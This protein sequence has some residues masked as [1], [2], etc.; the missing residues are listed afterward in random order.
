MREETR[1][2]QF[3][4][5]AKEFFLN[6]VRPRRFCKYCDRMRPEVDLDGDIYCAKCWTCIGGE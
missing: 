4:Y 5:L 6:L 2:E 1:W 3:V